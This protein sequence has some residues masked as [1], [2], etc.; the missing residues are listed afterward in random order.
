[1][2][3]TNTDSALRGASIRVWRKNSAYVGVTPFLFLVSIFLLWPTISVVS[4]AFQ[5]TNGKF[6]FGTIK[7]VI[8]SSIH[9]AAFKHSLQVSLI[10]SISG[11][12]IG[13]L[14]AWA[15]STGKRDGFLRRI[16]LSASGVLAQFGGVMLT[17]AFLATFG[18]NGLV[19]SFFLKFAPHSFFGHPTWLYSMTGLCI[20]YS[21]FQIPLMFLVF[22]PT[23]D[24]LKPQWREASDG[25][26]GSTF[27]YWR[28]VG[29]PVLTPA[30]LGSFLLLFA[31]SFSAYAT[32]ASLISQGSI[33]TPLEISG[34]ISSETGSSNPALAKALSLGMVVVVV[35]VMAL[36]TLLRK[37]VSRWEK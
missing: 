15:V 29:I 28:H 20:V 24:N 3:N 7:S 33:I 4:G 2:S 21:F 12:I 5:D 37:R 19:T 30:F 27:E 25:L 22:L 11:A 10:T 9:L 14:F 6:S 35:V 17:F 23:L 1:M 34:A 16:C 36:Y 18:F 13:A 32:A 26:G 8:T 31:N